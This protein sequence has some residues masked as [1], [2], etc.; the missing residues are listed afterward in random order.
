MWRSTK[1]RRSYVSPQLTLLRD[2]K[3]GYIM[4]K[5]GPPAVKLFVSAMCVALVTVD[6]TTNNWEIIDVIGNGNTLLTPLLNVDSSDDLAS[7]HS[8]PVGR[9]VESTS[10]VGIFMLNYTMRKMNLRDNSMYVLT[11]DDFLI[12]GPLNDICSTL[13]KT[14]QLPT[15]QTN[16]GS[17]VKLAT[18]KDSIQYIRGTAITN[19]LYGL[20]TPPPATTQHDEL[21]SMGFMPA[22]TDLDL[23]VTTGV[24][25]PPVGT[26]SYTNVTMYR[27]YP[28]AFCSGCEPVSELGLSVCQLTSTYNATTKTLVVSSSVANYGE[29]YSMGFMLERTGT[30]AGSLYVRGFCVLFV[31]A[32]FATSQKTVRWTD[33]ATLTSWYKKLTHMVA[34][35]LLRHPCHTLDFSYFCFNSDLFVLGYVVAVLLDEKSCNIYSRA[36]FS[37]NKNATASATSAWVFVRILA[38]N[39]RWMWLN[40]LLIKFLK[41]FVNFATATRYSGRNHLVAY[42]NFSTPTFVYIAGLF[43][44]ARNNLL[45]YGLLDSVN[46]ESSTQSLEGISVNIFNSVLFRGYPSLVLLMLINVFVILTVGWVVNRQWWHKVA[47]NSLGRQQ[48]YNS[49]SIIADVGYTFIDMGEYQGQVVLIPVRSLCTVQWFLTSQTIRFGLP[50]HP[51]VIRAMTSKGV[52]QLNTSNVTVGKRYS[53]SPSAKRDLAPTFSRRETNG[54]VHVDV[55]AT[56]AE[57]EVELLMVAQDLDGYIHL[58]NALKA[59]VQAPSMEGK[60]INDSKY[61]LA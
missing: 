61:Q 43:F 1:S 48:M 24:V 13:K 16:V 6:V 33:G 46:L 26:T 21:I 8:F 15:N 51:S 56:E 54:T 14:Y 32:A 42:L 49:T 34:P 25:V 36:M 44:V 7:E 53:S 5:Y 39:F 12:D 28:R 9:G 31:M 50:E 47:K 3:M 2:T 57:S 18:I 11:G 23:R 10:T 29:Y 37:W 17:T 22:R 38:M 55:E 40:C 59:E 20:G 41:W 19:L 30:T 4:A 27:F 35:T 60:V 52:S 45:D 58:Y